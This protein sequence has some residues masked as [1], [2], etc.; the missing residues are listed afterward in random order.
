MARQGPP[1]G[2]FG[3]M[4][5]YGDFVRRDFPGELGR[6]WDDWLQMGLA[7][8]RDILGERWLERYLMSPI[9]RFCLG[10]GLCGKAQ[11][12]GAMMPSVDRIGRYFPLTAVTDIPP[13]QSLFG[14]AARAASWFGRLEETLLAVLREESLTAEELQARL[15]AIARP[16]DAATTEAPTPRRLTDRGGFVSLRLAATDDLQDAA[17][18]LADALVQKSCGAFSLWWSGGSAYVSPDAR[19]YADLPPAELFWTLLDEPPGV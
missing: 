11:W 1:I 2:F 15:A 19:I 16:G 18:L 7:A 4:P 14:T 9:W 6:R 12:M 5:G 13:D 3:K 17:G 8:S 10:A